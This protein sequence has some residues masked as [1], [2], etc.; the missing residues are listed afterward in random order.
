[1]SAFIVSEKCISV[2][3]YNLFWNHDFKRYH[4]IFEDYGY[5]TAEDF[6]RLA[7]ELFRMN[8]E[9]V[10]QRYEE[11]DDSDYIK[12][13]KS[14]NWDEGK[15]DQYQTLKSMHCLRYQCTEGDVPETKLY[16]FL[17]EIIDQWADFIIEQIPEYQEARWD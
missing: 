4:H 5:I 8:R 2:I 15:L 7:M 10:K 3:I 6:D 1:M 17:D 13:P 16:K 11:P 14:V 9:A 12:I